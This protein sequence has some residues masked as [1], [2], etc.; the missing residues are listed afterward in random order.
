MRKLFQRYELRF[1]VKE[2]R[3]EAR[4]LAARQTPEACGPLE[5]SVVSN[6]HGLLV[7]N[8]PWRLEEAEGTG[9]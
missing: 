2:E 5:A 7:Q 1:Q 3:K 6:S 9:R 8:L 4:G